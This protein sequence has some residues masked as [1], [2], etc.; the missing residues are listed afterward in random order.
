MT[1]LYIRRRLFNKLRLYNDH[2]Y[3]FNQKSLKGYGASL[4][5]Y[6]LFVIIFL[7]DKFQLIKQTEIIPTTSTM[8]IFTIIASYMCV[9]VWKIKRYGLDLPGPD[10]IQKLDERIDHFVKGI[11]WRYKRQRK[12]VRFFSSV[13][14]DYFV[15]IPIAMLLAQ[16]FKAKEFHF[17]IETILLIVVIGALILGNLTSLR[18]ANRNFEDLQREPYVKVRNIVVNFLIQSRL[19]PRNK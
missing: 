8:I 13:Q 6:A 17:D 11:N 18:I 19:N 2:L 14:I 5:L 1:S 9:R 12:V 4:V 15:L 16:I 3:Y 7:M 10:E